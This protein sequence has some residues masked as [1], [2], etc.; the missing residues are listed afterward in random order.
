[1]KVKKL[2]NLWNKSG[3]TGCKWS[4]LNAQGCHPLTQSQDEIFRS[5]TFFASLSC[6]VRYPP[7]SPSS[8]APVE[9]RTQL[10]LHLRSCSNRLR[11]VRQ[12]SGKC[13]SFECIYWFLVCRQICWIS[14][15][16]YREVNKL[17]NSSHRNRQTRDQVINTNCPSSHPCI[18]MFEITLIINSF[19]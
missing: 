19:H 3:S 4:S 14:L 1:M 8:P 10:R 16:L 6:D 15:R 9:E 12:R 11:F 2:E 7:P 5:P 13:Q 18:H 17:W